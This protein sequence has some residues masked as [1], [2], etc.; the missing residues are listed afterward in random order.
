M[1]LFAAVVAAGGTGT[2][3]SLAGITKFYV[4]ILTAALAPPQ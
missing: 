2:H 1:P 4:P 3:P